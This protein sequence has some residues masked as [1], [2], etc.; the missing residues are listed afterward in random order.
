MRKICNVIVNV[1][2]K[3]F[4]YLCGWLQKNKPLVNI[5]S[6]F[7]EVAG[8]YGEIDRIVNTGDR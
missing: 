7:G 4:T 8:P 2:I 6:D 3:K 5:G 1:C